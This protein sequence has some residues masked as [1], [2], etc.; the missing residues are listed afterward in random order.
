MTE[1]D[2]QTIVDRA[3]ARAIEQHMPQLVEKAADRVE[4]RFFAN[5]G[6]QVV[7]KVLTWIGA[8][9]VALALYLYGSG[10]LK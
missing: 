1:S 8:G 5:V 7:S 4:Q 3:V 6:K 10:A 9:A 2:L